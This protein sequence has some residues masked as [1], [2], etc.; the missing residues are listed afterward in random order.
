M[1]LT[2]S[3][4]LGPP[5][6]NPG[7]RSPTRMKRG[8]FCHGRQDPAQ[9]RS[10]RRLFGAG[11]QYF[12]IHGLLCRMDDVRGAGYSHQGAAGSKRDSV[13]SVDRHAGADGLAGAGASGH[14]DRPLRWPHRAVPADAVH[15]ARH[16]AD[17]L[18]HRILAVPVAVAVRRSG[19]WFLLGGNALCGAL[20][21][22][23]PA[24]PGHGRV[25][26]RQLRFGHDQVH[27][28]AADGCGRWRLD[29]RAQGLFG[30]HARHG[31]D[32][33]VLLAHQPGAQC[34]LRHLAAHADAGAA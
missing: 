18:C 9:S 31:T 34:S 33:L 19:R 27:C 32:L 5:W 3:A 26:R 15:R 4:F 2:A 24:G 1:I 14:L 28:S 25:R 20:V 6:C 22:E 30:G 8:Y 7:E 21:P 23:G 13:R 11:F 10:P 16:L 29:H 17:G 12:R